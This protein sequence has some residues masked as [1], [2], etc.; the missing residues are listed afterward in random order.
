MNGDTDTYEVMVGTE[1]V[2]WCEGWGPIA[3]RGSCLRVKKQRENQG[4]QRRQDAWE[5]ERERKNNPWAWPW[6]PLL[7]PYL[8]GF[9]L[10][11]M[12]NGPL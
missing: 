5:R 2:V 12:H 1:I 7:A 11:H 9:F 10:R 6:D 8:L 4:W 3:S